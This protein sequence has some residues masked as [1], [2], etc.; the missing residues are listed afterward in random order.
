MHLI[1]T[2]VTSGLCRESHAVFPTLCPTVAASSR[3][4]SP[5]TSLSQV[6]I[7]KRCSPRHRAPWQF[8]LHP[9]QRRQSAVRQADCCS[10][11][12]R[13]DIARQTPRLLRTPPPLHQRSTLSGCPRRT[14]ST[15]GQSERVRSLLRIPLASSSPTSRS[16]SSGRRRSRPTIL[17]ISY[18]SEHKRIWR[19]LLWS[20]QFVV[21]S[22][23]LSGVHSPLSSSTPPSSPTQARRPDRLRLIGGVHGRRLSTFPPS[24][25]SVVALA[26]HCEKRS[27]FGRFVVHPFLI[28]VFP[29]A[30]SS[31][32]SQSSSSDRRRSRL[33]I[34]GIPAS[35]LVCEWFWRAAVRSLRASDVKD[36]HLFP[37]SSTPLSPHSGVSAQST[38]PGRAV[39]R[40]PHS[41]LIF[42]SKM[43]RLLP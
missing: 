10:Q 9:L 14:G 35:P 21:C 38:A 18:P 16:S 27:R 17:G 33:K 29:I 6:A 31:P 42:A 24:L 40:A 11:S 19:P 20:I 23:R 12:P 32:T 1:C 7:L 4:P 30:N 39:R 28:S 22:R 34:L 8:R 25:V 41:G 15:S 5:L 26:S 13:R 2:I 43:R 3:F 37:L 36:V